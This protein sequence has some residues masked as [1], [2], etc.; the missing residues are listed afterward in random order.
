MIADRW[1]AGLSINENEDFLRPTR[2][3]MQPPK[4]FKFKSKQPASSL[5]L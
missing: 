2:I 3:E 1:L 4:E 5:F